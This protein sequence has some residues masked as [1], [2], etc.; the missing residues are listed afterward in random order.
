SG[1]IAESL[2]TLIVPR[3]AAQV[4]FCTRRLTNNEQFRGSTDL[5][6]RFRPQGKK[7]SAQSAGTSFGYYFMNAIRHWYGTLICNR[8][9]I[10]DNRK[11]RM[12]CPRPIR[13]R[14]WRSALPAVYSRTK[15]V[16]HHQGDTAA[17][18][19]QSGSRSHFSFADIS[20]A[21]K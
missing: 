9:A 14:T 21:G 2:P 6:Y 11:S 8:E 1:P 16:Q 10:N 7:R 5:Y 12:C 15:H 18:D 20:T 17:P 19:R 3:H 4:G 13:P